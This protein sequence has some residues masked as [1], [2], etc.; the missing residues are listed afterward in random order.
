MSIDT[1]LA[2]AAVV[3]S[4]TVVLVEWALIE[5]SP[6]ELGTAFIVETSQL[7]MV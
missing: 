7:A 3:L 1:P 6:A 2:K 4:G 5:P